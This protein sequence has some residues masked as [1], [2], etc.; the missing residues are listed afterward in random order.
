MAAFYKQVRKLKKIGRAD[1]LI[2][3][4]ALANTGQIHLAHLRNVVPSS[5]DK[6]GW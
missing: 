3:S 4:I 2:A 6:H 1:L 5:S